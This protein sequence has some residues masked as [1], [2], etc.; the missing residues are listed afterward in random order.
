M[1]PLRRCLRMQRSEP[2]VCA[3]A[4]GSVVSVAALPCCK[5][6]MS[7]LEACSSWVNKSSALFLD[8]EESSPILLHCEFA[9]LKWN[10]QIIGVLLFNL[11]AVHTACK[12]ML[13]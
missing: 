7:L 2:S 8:T 1:L 3:S 13:N 10:R 5:T 6:C 9:V 12:L 11:F 4:K